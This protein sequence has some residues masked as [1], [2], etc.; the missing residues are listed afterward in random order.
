MNKKIIVCLLTTALLSTVPFVEAQQAKKIPRVAYL[1]SRGGLASNRESFR[2]GLREV[3][4]VE[5]QNI[6]IEYRYAEKPDRFPELASELV[7]LKFDVIVAAS[8]PAVL[9]LKQATGT[10]S[11]VFAAVADPIGTRL[12]TTLTRPG[13]NVTGLASLSPELSRRRLELFKETFSEVSRV[14][15]VFDPTSALDQTEL[16]ETQLAARALGVDLVALEVRGPKDFEPAFQSAIRKRTGGLIVLRGFFTSDLHKRIV[17]LAV[18]SR[19]PAIYND[20]VFTEAG[21][22]MYYG[23]ELSDLFRRS[24]TYV[25]KIL[26]GAK[27]ADLPVEQPT[28]FEMVINLNAAKQIGLTIPPNVLARADKVIK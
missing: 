27:P 20:Q 21:G 11:I 16:T 18:K 10:I 1:A 13:G 5:G 23:P 26:K 2:Q 28:K 8:T 6:V 12:V 19:M 22:L 3:G 15:V 4:Y 24:A 14:G 17:D 7:R 9:A 25:D